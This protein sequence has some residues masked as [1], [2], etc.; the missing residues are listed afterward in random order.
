MH[1]GNKVQYNTLNMG[2]K[3]EKGYYLGNKNDSQ[4]MR[5]VLP[6]PTLNNIVPNSAS[7]IERSKRTN[8]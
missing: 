8:Y 3:K 2:N 7:P 1:L 6:L 5:R 4:I